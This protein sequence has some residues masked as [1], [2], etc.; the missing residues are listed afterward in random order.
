MTEESVRL[1]TCLVVV[2][3][4]WVTAVVNLTVVVDRLVVVEVMEVVFSLC[5]F[6]VVLIFLEDVVVSSFSKDVDVVLSVLVAT[7]E[8]V[9]TEGTEVVVLGNVIVRR[10]AVVVVVLVVD[11]VDVLAVVAE[12]VVLL[13]SREGRVLLTMLLSTNVFVGN[14][15]AGGGIS[16]RQPSKMASTKT[17]AR[18]PCHRLWR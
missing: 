11:T 12:V 18:I 14:E 9:L 4:F 2:V 13:A 5:V 6:V 8:F 1:Y 7:A 17:T 3:G 16:K 15:G 10:D